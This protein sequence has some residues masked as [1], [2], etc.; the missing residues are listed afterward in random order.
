MRFSGR[1][2][3][4]RYE[5][6]PERETR[7]RVLR[8]LDGEVVSDVRAPARFLFHHVNAADV[9]GSV[10]VDWVSHLDPS[11]LGELR[12]DALRGPNPT[13][14]TGRLERTTIP[15]GA[16]GARVEPRPLAEEGLELPRMSPMLE[17][18][19]YRYLWGAGKHGSDAFF[20]HLVR[21]DLHTGSTTCFTQE[22]WYPGEPL[23]VPAPAS[24]GSSGANSEDEG[25]VLCT[26]LDARARTSR[27]VVLDAR[28]LQLLAQ[29]TLPHVVPFHFHSQFFGVETDS[30]SKSHSNQIPNE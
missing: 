27:F 26:M 6:R 30:P 25:V 15:L 5:W 29:A 19:R 10:E 18:R 23:F 8:K 17:G 3:I 1:A 13:A 14:L 22:G 11:I 9:D 16:V 4:E 2:F 28:D 24:S 20:D 12:L 7:I 21:V